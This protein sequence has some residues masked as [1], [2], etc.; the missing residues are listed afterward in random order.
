MGRL[1]LEAPRLPPTTSTLKLPSLALNVRLAA[2][3]G[4]TEV[5]DGLTDVALATKENSVRAGGGAE[6]ELVEGKSLTAGGDDALTSSGGETKSGNR[7]LGDLGETLVVK[8]SADDNNSLGVVG[9]R[10]TGLL[11]DAGEGDRRAVDLGSVVAL[12]VH[13]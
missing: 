10:A 4:S 12:G 6:G 1:D 7:E 5:L 11:D 8:D 9:V 3:E 13:V 2:L